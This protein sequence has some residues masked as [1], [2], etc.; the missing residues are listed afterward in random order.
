M[1]FIQ[2]SKIFYSFSVIVIIISLLSLLIWGFNFGID[3]TGGSLW[4]LSVAE[5][6]NQSTEKINNYLKESDLGQVDI[7]TTS[8]NSLILRF[9]NISEEKHIKLLGELKEIIPSVEERR[10]E[11]I[12]P[13]IGQELKTKSIWAIIL[14]FFGILT[15][16][17][18]AFRHSS[19]RV[20]SYRYGILAVL[21]LMHDAIFIIGLF[22]ILG[23]FQGWEVNSDFL[24]ALLVVIGYSVHDTIVVFDR[25]RENFKLKIKDS[26]E[27]IIN[28][29]IQQTLVR[30]LNTS[31]TT[32]FPLLTLYFFGPLSI[33][34][35]VVA[36]ISG[37][38]IGT[39]SSVFLAAPLLYEWSIKKA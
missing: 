8:E 33:K 28:L 19:L 9:S 18:Y 27:N 29:S 11:S 2:K 26:L 21:V 3:F 32:I 12:G 15:Y 23:K 13:S 14:V 4:E 25:I 6:I 37:V 38:I 1:N 16:L 10:F 22:V 34:I 31:L 30:S 35:L 5:N 7:Q 17:W 24:V 39:Y 36:M 20:P